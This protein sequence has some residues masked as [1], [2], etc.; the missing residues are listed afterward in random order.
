V[1]LLLISYFFPPHG[2]GGVLR[3]TETV[4]LL[5]ERGWEITVMAGPEDGWWVRDDSLL[6]RIP[7]SVRVIRPRPSGLSA[8][9]GVLRRGGNG[10]RNEGGIRWLKRLAAWLPVVDAYGAWVRAVARAAVDDGIRPD[11]IIS[12]SP[13]ESSHMVAMKLAEELGARWAADFRDPWT[14]GIYRRTPTLLHRHWHESRERKVIEQADLV[15]ATTEELAKDFRERYPKQPQDKVVNLPNGFDPEEFS[16][17]AAEPK[18]SKILRLIHAGNL[19]LDRDI[20]SLLEAMG[21][22]NRDGVLCRLELAGQVAPRIA[23]QVRELGLEEAVTIS[24]YISRPELL[25][26]LAKAHV[27]VLVEAFR[28]GA[29]LVVPGK[30]YD[31]LGASLPVVALVPDGAAANLIRQTSSGIAALEP[32]PLRLENLLRQLIENLRRGAPALRPPDPQQI[33]QYQR[34]RIVGTLASLLEKVY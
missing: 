6:A 24:G 11:W 22:I 32:D 3:A 4:R 13:P 5:A 25:S 31:Y 27:G 12:S 10:Q 23:C 14:A 9:F 20:S 18:P 21:R 17:V 34:T 28:P 2:G 15:I 29:E 30:L 16:E 26:R 19:T 8:L 33:E 1:K 7:S